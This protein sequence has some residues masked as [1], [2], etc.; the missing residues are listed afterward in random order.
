MIDQLYKINSKEG[1]KPRTYRRNLRKFFLNYSKNR[2]ATDKQIR[3]KKHQL[4]E[5]VARNLKH[6]D[7]LLDSIERKYGPRFPLSH[8]KQKLL[9]VIRN[10]YNQQLQMFKEN[11]KSCHD[12]IVNIYQPHVRPIPRGKAKAKTEFESKLGV[13]IDNGMARIDTFSW[14]AYNESTDLIKQVERYRDLHGYYPE[15]LLSD[16]IYA[17][18]TNRAYLSERGI[19]ITAPPLGRKISKSRVTAYRRRKHRLEAVQRNEI[20]AKFGQG[21]NG[22]NLNKIRARLKETSESWVA[23]IFFI[24]N[25]IKLSGH[26]SLTYFFVLWLL[27]KRVLAYLWEQFYDLEHILAPSELQ[28]EVSRV[29]VFY[30]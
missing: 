6:I 21:K 16:R 28:P 7:N 15:L 26:F 3:K 2:N 23:C 20:E 19:R 5:A 18:R 8:R 1:V 25:L 22:Y 29:R 17:N 27:P 12:P 13:S 14:D 10:V 4:L 24:M 30:R 9:W 11:N